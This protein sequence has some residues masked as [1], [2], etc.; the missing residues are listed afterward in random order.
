M[1]RKIN[2]HNMANGGMRKRVLFVMHMPPPVHGAAMMGQ[3]IHDSKLVNER[4]ECRYVNPSLSDNVANVGKVSLGKILFMLRNI[5]H[6][7][8]T[9]KSF[10]PDI[11]YYTPTSDGWGICRDVVVVTLLKRKCRRIVLHM[12]NKGVKNFSAQHP[13][14]RIAYKGIFGRSK[15]I[16]LAKE[17]YPDVREYVS[18]ED[19]R[20]CPNGIPVTSP[21]GFGRSAV[22]DTY[23]FLFL[24]NMIREKGVIDVLR[25]CAVLKGKGIMFRCGF[26]GKWSTV[27]EE[28]FHALVKELDIEQ[29][30]D[31]LGAKYGTDKLEVLKQAD[32]LVFPTYYPGE[33]FGLVLLEA[34]EYAMP[35]I[36]TREGGIPSV[37]DDGE[38]GFL[39]P[40]RDVTAL[41]DRMEW[42]VR[43]PAEGLEMGRRGREKFLREFTL[44]TFEQRMVEILEHLA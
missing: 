34:M 1:T 44:D 28:E 23:T 8:K 31:Y 10:R 11:V 38:T 21:T 18:A 2:Y 14:A 20:Y 37:V 26:V 22:N 41:A 19:V 7:V 13:L 12:H 36:S 42:L 15:V 35:C 29:E 4:F 17:L 40:A 5:M 30:V 6:I 16:L 24:S 43:H 9:A 32:A 3:Y 33:T 25:A 39:V 27:T